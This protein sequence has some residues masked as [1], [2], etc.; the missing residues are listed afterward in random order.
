MRQVPPNRDPTPFFQ[1]VLDSS[2]SSTPQ[3]GGTVKVVGSVTA[4][5]IEEP[6]SGASV[7][8]VVERGIPLDEPLPPSVV[9][10]DLEVTNVDVTF[11]NNIRTDTWIVD[12]PSVDVK[13]TS[14]VTFEGGLIV[15]GKSHLQGNVNGVNLVDLSET[16]LK[17]T[18]DQVIS[19]NK[20]FD[21]I[22]TSK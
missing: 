2:P 9:V 20:K 21:K 3:I 7:L 13:I 11:V 1:P 15:T 16:T 17:T 12:S 6:H 14:P 18:G 4:N 19:G 10:E 22:T 5:D 8:R